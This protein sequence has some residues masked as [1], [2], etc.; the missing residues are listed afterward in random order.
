[1]QFTCNTCALVFASAEEQR[2][3]MKSDWHRYNLKRRVAQLPAIDENVFNSKVASLSAESTTPAPTKTQNKQVTKKELRRREKEAKHKQKKQILEGARQNMLASSRERPVI[4]AEAEEALVSDQDLT[5]EHLAEKLMATKIAN[6]VHIPATTCL[7]CHPKDKKTFTTVEENNEHMFKLHGFYI[8]EQKYLQDMTGLIE[9]LGEKIGLGNVCLCC[10]YQGRNIEAV[11]EHM[12]VKR[13][14]KVPYE[15]EDDKYEISQFYDFSSTY[16]DATTHTDVNDDK[17]AD[18][19]EDVSGDEDSGSGLDG[20]SDDEVD[21]QDDLLLNNGHELVLP[22]GAIV[23]HRSMARYYRQNLAP[24][25]ILS[26]GQG[27]VIAAETRHMLKVKDRQ[28]LATQKRAW[29]RQQKREDQ[30]DRRAQKFINNQPHFRDPLL[31]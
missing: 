19:W 20:E 11:R 24:E 10:S 4:E 7:F 3:H 15:S 12:R 2:V 26:E 31:Q 23:G 29:A 17:G 30:N 8:P 6:Q 13:H 28:E 14:M 5:E 9:Y 27:T 21:A 16:E 25:R 18:D 22:S 1:M